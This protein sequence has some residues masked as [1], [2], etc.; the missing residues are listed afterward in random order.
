ML[1]GRLI[2]GM[3]DGWVNTNCYIFLMGESN[4]DTA[5]GFIEA[6]KGIAFMIGPVLGS[7]LYSWLGFGAA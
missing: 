3:G 2:G 4:L 7:T 5:I 6:G 1:C